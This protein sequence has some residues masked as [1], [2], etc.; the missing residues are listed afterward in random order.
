MNV[1]LANLNEIV[2]IKKFI[3]NNW[4]KK[5]ILSINSKLLK[6]QHRNINK[7]KLSIVI[8]ENTEKKVVGILGF[9]SINDYSKN[10]LKKDHVWLGIWC[11]DKNINKV[12][13]LKL[14]YYFLNNSKYKYIGGIGLTKNII[15]LY[16]KLNFKVGEMK[17]FYILNNTVKKTIIS[18]NLIKNNF[19][20]ERNFKIKENKSISKSIFNHKVISFKN[21]NYFKYRYEKHPIYR[22]RFLN[23]QKNNKNVLLI[24]VRKIKVENYSIIRIIDTFGDWSSVS[25]IGSL[26]HKFLIKEKSEY[27]DFLY[28]GFNEKYILLNGFKIKKN[29]KIIPNHFEPY[30]GIKNQPLY[31]CYKSEIDFE[32][33]KGDAD[34]D[35]PNLIY[36]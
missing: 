12:Y 6:W 23:I 29:K 16:K 10:N 28:K 22:Y 30:E 24:I 33:H 32:L 1:R 18:K 25:N 4:K 31:Y 36:S 34:S 17:H 2:N 11:L 14:I 7:Q 19:L 27:I 9:I 26:L 3:D 20:I 21:Y 5:H 13:G 35:R 15:Q 8:L